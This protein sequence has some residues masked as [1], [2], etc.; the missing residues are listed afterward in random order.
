MQS[1]K[2]GNESLTDT[3]LGWSQAG[4][5][6]GM[7]NAFALR[8]RTGTRRVLPGSH[9]CLEAAEPFLTPRPL[10]LFLALFM[11]PP[12][13]LRSREGEVHKL[14]FGVRN[15]SH[16]VR[17]RHRRET[18]E[19]IELAGEGPSAQGTARCASRG[20]RHRLFGAGDIAAIICLSR[21][22][23]RLLRIFVPKQASKELCGKPCP[24]CG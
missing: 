10:T 3:Q 22:L 21:S 9:V 18:S 15:G 8:G 24:L 2:S 1:E 14:G 17:S 13:Y 12:P 4:I 23:Y 7:R 11:T 16:T 19:S 6:H 20:H 5:A